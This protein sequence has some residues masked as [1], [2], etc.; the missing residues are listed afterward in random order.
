MHVLPP[1]YG[2]APPAVPPTPAAVLARSVL[3][4]L[5]LHLWLLLWLGNVPGGSAEPGRGV[6]GA[7]DIR[8]GS[9]QGVLDE[10]DRAPAS[11][12]SLPGLEGPAERDRAG[13]TVRAEA[14]APAPDS[15]PGA[16]R[17]G[18]WRVAPLEAVRPRDAL[19]SPAAVAMLPELPELVRP[20]AALNEPAPAARLL[21]PAQ[22]RLSPS[23][24]ALAA[25][26]AALLA[27]T[28]LA[29]PLPSWTEAAPLAELDRL[30][31]LAEPPRALAR[32]PE[33]AVQV[34]ALESPPPAVEAAAAI[35]PAL[36][37]LSAGQPAA[38]RG[39][40][41][42]GAPD[43]GP[44]TGHDVATPPSAAAS[45]PRLDLSLPPRRGAAL[46]RG[47][48]PGVLELLPRPPEQPSKLA[49]ELDKAGREDCRKA[50][51]GAGLLAVVPLLRDAVSGKGC[52]W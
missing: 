15:A 3:L 48:T 46:S 51:G 40:P 23:L 14:A 17:L 29:A 24:P 32:S 38:A 42:A 31:T 34:P 27:P 45:Q 11:T 5:L 41:A 43:A 4:A 2:P 21:P 35:G 52:K 16:A 12:P 36:P 13:G 22:A 33:G 26:Q 47:L 28:P 30:R 8:L 49:Q 1:G 18:D 39:G 10:L 9:P 19:P 20:E 50:Y 7:I 6:W 44:W 25:Q 37:H